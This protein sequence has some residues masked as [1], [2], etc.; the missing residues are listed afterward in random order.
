M[1]VMRL[2]MSRQ[3][4]RHSAMQSCER[5]QRLEPCW[6]W[7]LQTEG[8]LQLPAQN[9]VTQLCQNSKATDKSK[10][11][12]VA[13]S[14]QSTASK[15][16][17]RIRR[18]AVV[19]LYGQKPNWRDGRISQSC[20][21]LLSCYATIHSRS[22]DTTERIRLSIHGIRPRF[23][24]D[25]RYEGSL[26]GDTNCPVKWSVEQLRQELCDLI[27]YQLH[28]QHWKRVSSRAFIRHP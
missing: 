28:Y 3:T 25:Q 27:C 6:N 23:L 22:F 13:M 12:K 26:N 17:D 16:V 14:P 18:T 21:Y 24:D 10:R 15:T 11:V 4:S 8:Q 20:R 5:P 7:S 19:K 1:S 2:S 9:D